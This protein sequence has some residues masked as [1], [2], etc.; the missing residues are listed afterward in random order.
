MAWWTRRWG[1]RRPAGIGGALGAAA[2]V[3]ATGCSPFLDLDRDRL[4]PDG[5]V[6]PDGGPVA[7]DCLR[8]GD[9]DGN[10]LEDCADFACAGVA[11][12]CTSDNPPPPEQVDWTDLDGWDVVPTADPRAPDVDVPGRR[13][14]GFG[15]GEVPR[16]LV[17]RACLPLAVG[18]SLSARLVPRAGGL[19]SAP[20]CEAGLVLTAAR[21]MAPGASLLEEIAVRLDGDG[22]LFATRAGATVAEAD[23]GVGIGQ[24][25]RVELELGPGFDAEDRPVLLVSARATV[26]TPT[27]RVLTLLEDAPLLRRGDLVRDRPA[28]DDAPGLFI[29]V[30]GRG[31]TVEVEP[32]TLQARD[33]VNPSQFEP[34]RDPPVTLDA[35][36]LGLGG[37]AG[38]GIAAPTVAASR[39]GDDV[40]WDL[41]FEATDVDPTLEQVTR[42]GYALDHAVALGEPWEAASFEVRGGATP[43]AGD[44]RPSCLVPGAPACEAVTACGGATPPASLREP[45]LAPTLD[46]DGGLALLGLAHALELDPPSE[47]FGLAAYPF[48]PPDVA[49]ALSTAATPTL[50]PADLADAEE[51]EKRCDSLRDPALVPASGAALGPYFLF[52][53]CERGGAPDEVH[54]VTLTLPDLAVVPGSHVRLV[55]PDGDPRVARFGAG[56]V[57]APEPLLERTDDGAGTLRVWYL[58]RESAGAPARLAVSVGAVTPAAGDATPALPSREDLV[59]YPANP[60][61]GA[62][63]PALG[64]CPGVCDLTGVGVTPRPD[65]AGRLRFVVARRVDTGS[66]VTYE[67]RPLEQAWRAP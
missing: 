48:F 4:G 13:L 42:V 38:G 25:A 54:A 62:D 6:D 45:H 40:R 16:G 10:G 24:A 58:A 21:D 32:L 12:C 2:A 37:W 1:R 47:R 9:E 50:A 35:P 5:G 51:A 63:D 67:I 34:T 18:A 66:A 44:C 7:E 29:A 27:P 49:T 61:L 57:R 19:C 65:L 28:C 31:A 15:V 20:P 41:A 23:A 56:G 46:D 39:A 60:V 43:K 8:P 52:F 53:T 22:R 55:S 26:A 36:G 30:E 33:C 11:E 59:P 17:R 64:G 14:V 3:L